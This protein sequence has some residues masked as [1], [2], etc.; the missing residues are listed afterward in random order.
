MAIGD[1]ETFYTEQRIWRL[2]QQLQA[3]PEFE[4]L[5]VT[6]DE[7]V[8]KIA[9][10]FGIQTALVPLQARRTT[11]DDQL[12]T[13]NELISATAD[14]VI[15]GSQLPLWKSIAPD[16]FRGSMLLFGARPDLSLNVDLVIVPLMCV[17]SN[18]LKSAGLYT[19]I[20]SQA[21]AQQIPI[22]G[23]EVSPLGNRYT[24]SQLPAD[25]YTVKSVWSNNFFIR[26]GMAA[27]E[28]I[29]VLTP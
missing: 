29:C 23:L 18:T 10:D 3:R 16:E 15:P 17:D 12:S 27:P 7:A 1:A 25:H 5:S 4:V 13:V 21:R 19:V 24:M 14:I 26:Q 22:L 8:R 2:A 20:V 28:H 11:W 9:A 6:S